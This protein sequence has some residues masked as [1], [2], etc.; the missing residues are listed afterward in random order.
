MSAED[1]ITMLYVFGSLVAAAILLVFVCGLLWHSSLRR[2]QQ[3]LQ[4][5]AERCRRLL[6][7]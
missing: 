5:M 2:M 3:I 4:G 1:L 7:R 6:A